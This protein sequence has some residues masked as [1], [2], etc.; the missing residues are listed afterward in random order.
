MSDATDLVANMVQDTVL[1][2]VAAVNLHVDT[3]Q[4]LY[5][6]RRG[7]AGGRRRDAGFHVLEWGCTSQDERRPLKVNM[8][9][10]LTH[11]Q[12]AGDHYDIIPAGFLSQRLFEGT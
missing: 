7:A 2:P 1:T 5:Y 11:A 6:V 4:P 8:E 10:D 3:D 12:Q 9:D